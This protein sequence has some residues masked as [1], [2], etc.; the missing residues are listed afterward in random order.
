MPPELQVSPCRKCSSAWP[1][2][3]RRPRLSVSPYGLVQPVFPP[4]PPTEAGTSLPLN[5]SLLLKSLARLPSASAE[6][7][8]KTQFLLGQVVT[9]YEQCRCQ[10][11]SSIGYER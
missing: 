7:L 11:R 10:P 1:D 9:L 8:L 3:D 2:R 5:T 6:P 4:L